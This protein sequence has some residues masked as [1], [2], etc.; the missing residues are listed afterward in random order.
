MP[1]KKP[2][3][4]NKNKNKTKKQQKNAV[5]KS[6]DDVSSVEEIIVT[7]ATNPSVSDAPLEEIHTDTIISE[8]ELAEI[9]KHEEY[10]WKNY[11]A[12]EH[13]EKMK[14]WHQAQIAM[15]DDPEYWED[16]RTQLLRNRERFHKMAAWSP[17]VFHQVNIIDK[18]IQHCETTM[19]RLD[20]FELEIPVGNPILGGMDWWKDGLQET[21]GWVSSK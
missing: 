2:T 5:G 4:T 17:E 12:P 1:F 7:D 21:D 14:H 16:R 8:E 15:L 10:M 20:G 3:N 9:A 6:T 18:E 11:Y 13:E 19:D